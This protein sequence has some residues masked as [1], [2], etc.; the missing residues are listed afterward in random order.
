MTAGAITVLRPC[1]LQDLEWR[2]GLSAGGSNNLAPSLIAQHAVGA[3]MRQIDS[4]I[5]GVRA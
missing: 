4:A 3:S 2:F 1:A 5:H